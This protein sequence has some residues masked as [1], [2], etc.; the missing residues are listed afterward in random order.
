MSMYHVLI[1]R[2]QGVPLTD[3]AKEVFRS[4]H[5]GFAKDA[6]DNHRARTG[7]NCI[8]EG[9]TVVYVTQ[10][11][12]EAMA[13]DPT[14]K[15]FPE[16]V[17]IL[18]APSGKYFRS[19]QAFARAVDQAAADKRHVHVGDHQ[20]EPRDMGTRMMGCSDSDR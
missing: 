12:V 18:P 5:Y 16:S 10:T 7:E 17:A 4:E 13:G 20:P 1:M 6:A 9:R 8:I 3:E 19:A 14:G 2:G 11:L 15:A